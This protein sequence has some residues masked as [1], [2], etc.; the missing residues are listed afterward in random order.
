[1]SI[2]PSESAHAAD[3]GQLIFESALTATTDAIFVAALHGADL[4][5]ARL[6]FVNSAFATITGHAAADVVGQ[7]PFP[8]LACSPSGATS[9]QHAVGPDA[10][11]REELLR[12]CRR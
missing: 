7:S 8:L 9:M 4:S 6:V 11:T 1:M 3:P 12:R 10:G 5:S 2:I